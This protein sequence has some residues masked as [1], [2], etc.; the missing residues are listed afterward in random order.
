MIPKQLKEH[1]FKKGNPGGKG[2][3]MI[4]PVRL[5]QPRVTEEQAHKLEAKRKEMDFKNSTDVI[6]W[7]ID[8]YL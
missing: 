3:A 7:L 8:E 5:T 4:Y 6:R 1:T 2:K